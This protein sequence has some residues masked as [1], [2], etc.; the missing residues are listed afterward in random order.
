MRQ[1]S[2]PVDVSSPSSA[3]ART[4]RPVLWRE[5][6]NLIASLLLVI[7]VAFNLYQLYPEAA[8]KVPAL[9]D[10]V[11]HLV[12]L[13]RTVDALAAGQDPTD[14]W[15][16]SIAMG[17]PLFH[18]YQHLPYLIPALLY[19]PV[20]GAL[21]IADVLRWI[22]Y[23]L[24]SLF[25]LAIY[26]S[27]R[28]FGF[29]RLPSA[30]AG[31][32]AP[33]IAT[34]GLYG[35]EYGSYVWRGYGLYT[36]LW[37]MVLLPMAV[38]QCYA[39]L[40]EGR[41]YFWA[42]VLLAAT[43]MSHV[44]MGYIA[45]GSV[46]L[47]VFLGGWRSPAQPPARD[48][49]WDRIKRLALLLLAVA[50][51]TS[52]FVI[53]FLRDS[54]YMNRSVWEKADKYDSYGYET[55]LGTLAKGDLFD[56]GRFPTL[57]LLAGLGLAV[58][59]WRW[60][61]VRCRVLV[62]LPLMWLL[63]YFGR[64]TWGALLSLLPMSRDLQLHR[65]IAGVHLGGIL[66]MGVGLALPWSWALARR[67]A[68]AVLVVAALT[69]AAMYPVYR[70]RVAYL[71]D[72]VKWMAEQRTASQAEE[73]DL[74]ELVSTINKLPPGRVYAGLAAK[75][76]KDY[77]VG[78]VPM[79]ALLN[80][81]KLDMLGYLYHALSL[82]ADIQIL[83]NDG[84]QEQ[85][86]LF[87]VRYVLTPTDWTVPNYYKT[88]QDF[89]RHRLYQI[90]TTGYF[91]LVGSDL[92]FWGSK[93]DFYGAA[94]SWLASGMV[95]ARQ[96]PTLYLAATR[97]ERQRSFPL[98]Q[99]RQIIAEAPV[100]PE[101]P[102][103]SIVSETVESNA[104]AAQVQVER[105][106]MLMLKATYHP[107]WRATVDGVE[108]R[109]VMLMP[110]Y[111]G[112]KVTP[113]AHQVRFEYQAGPLRGVLMIVGALTLALIALAERRRDRLTQIAGRLD[114]ERWTD[115]L[116]RMARQW[117]AWAH[118]Q[119]VLG[120]LGP[121]LPYLGGVALVA[122]LAGLSC[123][124]LKLM[125][126]HDAL[127]YLPRNVEFYR[128]LEAGQFYPRWAPDL[129]GGY[130]EPFFSFNPP[131]IYY[132]SALFHAI[133]SSMVAAANWAILT[134]LLIGAVGMYLLAGEFFG[135]RGGLVSAAAYVF[136]PYLLVTLYV[137]SALADFSAFAFIPLALWGLYCHVRDGRTVHLYAGA[138]SAA[139]L[140]LS[141]NPVS[142][143]TFPALALLV[144]WQAW[145][146]K[147]V[148][149]LVRGAW[150]LT[151]GMGLS[152]V[153]WLPALL[154]RNFVHVHRLL[155]TFLN[156]RN[157]FA[158]L[159]QL[160][161]SPWGYGVSLPGPVDG[162]SFAIGPAHLALAAIAL[163]LLGRIR[164]RSSQAGLMAAFS[165]VLILIG[166]FF[167]IYESQLIWDRLSLLQYLEY[168]WRFLTLA[169]V[170]AAF[171]C[172]FPFLFMATGRDRLANGLM[173][174]MISG[175]VALNLSHARPEQFY[176]TKD[177][178]YSPQ[179]IAGKGLAVTTAREYEPIWVQE[180]PPTPARETLTI[181]Q[182]QGR[183]VANQLT[184]TTREF[185]VEITQDARLRLNT[186][187]FPGWTLYVDGAQRPIEY[188]NPQ[189]V[190]EFPLEP[191]LHGI[192]IVFAD[193]PVRVW[194]AR[195]SLLALLLLLLSPPIP[196]SLHAGTTHAI[197]SRHAHQSLRQT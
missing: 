48:H 71:A 40:R 22:T 158:T 137:R 56:Y 79:Y 163:L 26:G 94:S 51:A 186:F 81:A 8:I 46:V 176:T 192:K 43:V 174:V 133:G 179:V 17:Y 99:A 188:G 170:G 100:A 123:L 139:L 89:G 92:A 178:D 127:E 67:D 31:L 161:N 189:G 54:A 59:V 65:L 2:D 105:E 197:R 116:Q 113:G 167:S 175:L 190:I 144:C 114:L 45:L 120:R 169:T 152:A 66:L 95:Q 125:S 132:L 7:A 187:Y 34:N 107:N 55:V 121:H 21:P 141:S 109:T 19:F 151:V 171:L 13:Q 108:A 30:L 97:D 129:S 117:A 157:H 41:G 194:S 1:Q 184:A 181:L 29:A 39:V 77:K 37:G 185:A 69:A 68:R 87:N 112:V 145:A 115:G 195:L 154:E 84:L 9:N 96:H 24:L 98:S 10:T 63:L 47:L 73:K 122:L 58:C 102:R 155:E 57:T 168:P 106:S 173:V 193:T 32:V 104:Y 90:E 14:A 75:W 3:G 23:L 6:E 143:I 36:Q 62:A 177:S 33:L 91:D 140:L 53:P 83:Y 110:S 93:D 88:V 119:A 147:S 101:P 149:R 5:P 50:L 148:Q 135:R 64:P 136:A 180:L 18:S 4:R 166:A 86:N 118:L 82:N 27:M 12:N 76:G 164:A 156:Y 35:L 74:N 25:P 15:L 150:C 16:G 146:G 42:V 128:A 183:I 60:R 20:R 111:I 85:Y 131:V 162:M 130:G 28:R 44:V 138:M 165:L 172:G 160:F 80:D 78:W 61:D 49:V 182:G 126:G 191:G 52:F 142:L 134:C 153:F 124:Q 70:E 103:G 11:L 38:A 196:A 159:A 72:N